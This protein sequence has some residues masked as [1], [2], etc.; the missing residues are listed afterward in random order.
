MIFF[1]NLCVWFILASKE[2]E[3]LLKVNIVRNHDIIAFEGKAAI[4]D[5]TLFR[6]YLTGLQ[7]LID[8]L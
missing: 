5:W 7:I 4:I 3:C 1:C 6:Q 8:S 2:I